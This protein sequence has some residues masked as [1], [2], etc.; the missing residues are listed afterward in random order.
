MRPQIAQAFAV[1]AQL[2]VMNMGQNCTATNSHSPVHQPPFIQVAADPWAWLS[3]DFQQVPQYRRMT[4]VGP[5][6]C[7]L[8]K[9]SRIA[10]V[11][12]GTNT[13]SSLTTSVAEL[14]M[15][16]LPRRDARPPLFT[17]HNTIRH[18]RRDKRLPSGVLD[19]EPSTTHR[20]SVGATGSWR[21]RFAAN[22]RPLQS[23]GVLRAPDFGA[24]KHR[25]RNQQAG[26][27]CSCAPLH[28]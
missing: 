19:C 9:M 12:K 17:G 24:L 25:R 27:H 20:V 21:Q 28:S 5:L 13:K 14:S 23:T 6:F 18:L 10:D 3:S 16:R 11:R 1:K 26:L 7:F 2:T 22:D 8:A 4:T 15:E